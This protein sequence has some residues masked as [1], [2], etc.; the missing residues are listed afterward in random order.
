MA[1]NII[2]TAAGSATLINGYTYA[3]TAVG[4]PA[5][6]GTIACLNGGLNNLIAAT[7]HISAGIVW[8]GS[9]T[10]TGATSTTDGASNTTTIVTVLGNNGGTAY[11]A[12]WCSDY[13]VD[14]KGNT[15]C[16]TGN[17]CYND[18][19]LP[20]GLNTS[21]SGQLN[22]LYTNQTA[23]G[24]FSPTIYWSSTESSNINAWHQSFSDGTQ[25][26]ENKNVPR[27]VICVRA[28]TP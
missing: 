4:Q 16:Q 20:A 18:W 17:T 7:S 15:P 27:Y 12:K 28:F 19:F 1:I 9:G 25:I 2:T 3:T 6:G 23:I 14:S 11:A 13:E 26:V 8:G 10:T 22:C 24:G 21:S 5:Y